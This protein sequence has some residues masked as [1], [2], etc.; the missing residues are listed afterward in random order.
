MNIFDKDRPEGYDDE[1]D[2]K[3]KIHPEP[4]GKPEHLA[5]SAE[6][7][8]EFIEH[9]DQEGTPLSGEQGAP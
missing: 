5:V 3:A 7:I 4:L 2:G 1:K 8:E 9:F 6:D